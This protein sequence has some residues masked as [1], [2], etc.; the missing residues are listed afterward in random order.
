MLITFEGSEGSGKSSQIPGLARMLEEKGWD[1]LTTREPGGTPIGDQIRAV[2]LNDMRNTDMNPRTEILLFQASR[3]QL[4][5]QVIRPHLQK[6]GVVLCDRYADSTLAYQ[7]YGYQ[8]DL[9]QLKTLISFATCNLKPDLTILF[10]MDVEEGL[11]RKTPGLDWNRL[12]TYQI[13]FYQRVRQGY[14]EMAR[15]E[16]ERWVAIDASRSRQAV[17]RELEEIVLE[18]LK[19]NK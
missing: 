19:S 11:R 9:D 16:P 10:D 6:G 2:L 7:G 13:E 8:R 14:L 1:V 18:R 15:Q 3:A 4:V 12:D 17:Q 5:E